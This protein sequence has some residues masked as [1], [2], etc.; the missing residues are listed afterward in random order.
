MIKETT[1]GVFAENKK[2]GLTIK[3]PAGWMTEKMELKEGWVMFYSPDTE[4]E[5]KEENMVL[6]PLKK[7]CMIESGVMYLSLIHI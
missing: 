7:G 5:W 2:A 6:L 1:E 4:I 3:A